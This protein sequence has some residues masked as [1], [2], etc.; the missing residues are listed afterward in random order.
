MASDASKD[1]GPDLTKGVS[2]AD[3]HDGPLLRG[4]VGDEPVVLARVGDE[5]LAV[6]A[7]CTH[8]GGPL[9]KGRIVG[10]TLRP[11]VLRQG[12]QDV[13]Q[14]GCPEHPAG[15]ASQCGDKGLHLSQ[16]P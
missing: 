12:V 10:E 16:S 11:A 7:A 15:V 3:F 2:L 14:F 4:V 9:D 1:P 5:V 6:G 13:D 8:Y